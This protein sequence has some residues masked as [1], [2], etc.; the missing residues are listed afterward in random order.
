LILSK[1]A[2]DE[3]IDNVWPEPWTLPFRIH[4]LGTPRRQ[5]HKDRLES[6]LPSLRDGSR[7]WNH[8]LLIT[9]VTVFV[10]SERYTIPTGRFSFKSWEKCRL[11]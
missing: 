6:T 7:Q 5:L 1:P 11:R 10:P 8:V 2:A 9:P 4:P 3:V